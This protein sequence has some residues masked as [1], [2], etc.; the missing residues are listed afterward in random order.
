M[1]DLN[2]EI[3]ENP[4]PTF[5]HPNSR[6]RIQTFV[7]GESMTHQSHAESCDINNI[8]SRYENTGYLPEATTSAQFAD[9]TGLQVD[10]T[11]AINNSRSIVSAANEY[12]ANPPQQAPAVESTSAPE[13]QPP[14]VENL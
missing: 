6:I 2:D 12:L 9:V 13:S 7:V 8:I 5:R 14:S 1:S 11:E 3:Y 10:L 4:I